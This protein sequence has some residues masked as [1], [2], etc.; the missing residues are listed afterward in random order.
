MLRAPIGDGVIRDARTGELIEVPAAVD[1]QTV[2]ASQQHL[3]ERETEDVDLL[4]IVDRNEEV[5]GADL[6]SVTAGNDEY[7]HPCVNF[8]MSAQGAARMVALTGGNLPYGNGQSYRRLAILLD[9]QVLSAPRIIGPIRDKGRITGNFTREEVVFLVAILRAGRLPVQLEKM[10]IS[11]HQIAANSTMRQAAVFIVATALGVLVVIWLLLVLRHGLIG[12]GSTLASLLQILFTLVVVELI[13]VTVNM[14]SVISTTAMSL[15]TVVGL[16]ADL[17]VRARTQTQYGECVE[18]HAA[19]C[20]VQCDS[21]CI[22]IGSSMVGGNGRVRAR[23]LPGSQSRDTRGDW[24]YC[25]LGDSLF[26]PV[27]A[28]IHACQRLSGPEARRSYRRYVDVSSGIAAYCSLRFVG[29]RGS[30]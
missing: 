19:R 30:C 28:H 15:L 24:Q 20:D 23:E 12:V 6:T 7:L 2:Q 9:R 29:G 18:G 27:V 4:L 26:L 17:R 11:E 16:S 25:C 8:Q 13:H 22:P 5:T 14:P 10:P 3:L 1:T 21:V